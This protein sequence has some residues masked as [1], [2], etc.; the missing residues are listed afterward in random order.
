VICQVTTLRKPFLTQ[1]LMAQQ[2]AS[3]KLVFTGDAA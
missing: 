1:A 3:G 2:R